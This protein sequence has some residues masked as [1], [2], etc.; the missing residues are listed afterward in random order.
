[1]TDF[2]IE[3]SDTYRKSSNYRIFMDALMGVINEINSLTKTWELHWWNIIHARNPYSVQSDKD[4]L[5]D[6]KVKSLSNEL[7]LLF[8]KRD[9][10]INKI[11][12]ELPARSF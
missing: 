3:V 1:M 12:L 7:S 9:E 4:R 5:P 11:N 10:I 8:K 2:S 6:T